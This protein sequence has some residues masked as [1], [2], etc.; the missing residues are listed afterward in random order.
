MLASA[1][2]S[3]SSCSTNQATRHGR[4][5]SHCCNSRPPGCTRLRRPSLTV[6]SDRELA[7][8]QLAQTA[9]QRKTATVIPALIEAV[10]AGG[11]GRGGVAAAAFGDVQV[12]DVF[13]GRD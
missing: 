4:P 10:E 8:T 6:T 9:T 11:F 2:V 7:A 12:A 5:R 3:Y 13:E 1:A